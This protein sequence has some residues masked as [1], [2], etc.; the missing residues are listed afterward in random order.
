L[1]SVLPEKKATAS[2]QLSIVFFVVQNR[3]TQRIFMLQ[4]VKATSA[5]CDMKICCA[6]VFQAATYNATHWLH[7]SQF[8]APGQ[9][10]LYECSWQ[11]Y[12]TPLGTG[13]IKTETEIYFHT[14]SLDP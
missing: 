8:L 12:H 6:P 1:S 14:L 11:S 2:H 3:G 9:T 7:L 4:K 10:W 13:D 5:L